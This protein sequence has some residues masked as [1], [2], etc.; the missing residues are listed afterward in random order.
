MAF[1]DL[2]EFVAFLEEKGDLRR[3]TT[4]V[5]TELEITEIT[6]RVVKSDGPALLFEN[7]EGHDT[8]VLINIYGSHRRV[9]WALGVEHIDE[10]TERVRKL[11]ALAKDGPPSG[12]INK[13][14]TLG[15]IVG[16]ARTQPKL[17]SQAPCQEV[18]L[19]GGEVD[20]GAFPILKC[21]PL[22]AG[23]FITLPLVISKDP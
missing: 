6:D 8:P 2:R 14:R 23:P 3:I 18:V 22:D 16:V 15:D 21:W 10:L 4:P 13:L 19:T 17:V 5:S 9:A 12:L 20:L 11:L 1:K 7:V